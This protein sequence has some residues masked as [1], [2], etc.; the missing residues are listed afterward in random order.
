MADDRI[1]LAHGA[2]GRLTQQLITDVFAPAFHNDV[3]AQLNDAALLSL[4]G[5]ARLAFSTDAHVVQPLF[6]PGGDIGELAVFGTVNDLAMMGARPLWLAAAFVLEEGLPLNDLRHVVESMAAAAAR[7]GVQLV[8]GDTKV[9]PRGQADGMYISVAGV[10]LVPEGVHVAAHAAQ[11]GDVVLVNAPIAAHGM[12]VMLQ[13]EGLRM[14][15]DLES[16][17]A[18]LY[19]VVAALLAAAPHTHTLRDA[20]RGGLATVLVEIAQAAH[21]GVLV[22]ETDIPV[23]PVAQEA[24]AL[25]GLDPMYVANEGVFVAFVPPEEAESALCA[26]RAHPLGRQVRAIG[27]VM[28]AP[29]GQVV[30][31]TA[32]G[33]RR[34]LP[35]LSGNLL[36][37]IC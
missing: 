8:A 32:L 17:A 29:A 16:D 20:T 35:M 26:L 37:R 22:R 28:D 3:L 18:P 34:L 7:A 5:Q 9:V 21:V 1:T 10:G 4:Q 12:A 27:E 2:G 36:P 25:L 11:P 15:A 24:C 6:F 19:D 30:L 31:E 23:H 14:D 33:A 13:R